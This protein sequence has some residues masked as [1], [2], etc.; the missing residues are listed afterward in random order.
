MSALSRDPE[1]AHAS[2][3]DMTAHHNETTTAR[4]MIPP[5]RFL[6][7]SGSGGGIAH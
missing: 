1:W 3:R 4:Q 6:G 2:R 7:F 5:P